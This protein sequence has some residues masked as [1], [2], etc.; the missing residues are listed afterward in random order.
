MTAAALFTGDASAPVEVVHQATGAASLVWL[1]VALPLLSAMLLLVGGRRTNSW[2]PYLGVGVVWVGFGIGF[3]QFLQMLG[4]PTAARPVGQS[5]YTWAQSGLFDVKVQFLLDELSM[6]FV[7][8]ITFVGGLIHVYSLGYMKE[9]PDRRRFFAYLNLFVASMLLL[10]VAGNYVMVY[11]GWEG[12]GLASYLLIGFWN[13][14]RTYATAGN[15]AFVMN[16]LGDMGMSIA[17]MV[18]FAT[19]GTSTFTGVFAK[20]PDASST[21]TL[22]LGLLLLL[23]AVGKSAQIPLQAWLL[24]AMAGPTPV[25]ALIHAATMVTAGVYLIVRSGPI[26]DLTDTAR[27]VVALVGVLTLLLGALIGTA[28]DDIKKALA[29]STMSQIGYMVLAAG[30]GPA[31][32]AFAIFHLLMHGFFKANLFLGAGS[33]MHAMN[34]ELDMRRFGGLRKLLPI[35]FLTFMAGYLAIIGVPPFDGFYSKD[36]I[37][38]AAFGQNLW[39]G[40]A[41][42]VGAGI[43]GYY[44]TRVVIMTWFGP[45]RWDDEV[46]PHESPWVM[47]VPLIFLGVLSTVA[48]FI[49]AKDSRF[50]DWLAPVVGAPPESALSV[51]TWVVSVG[52]LALVGVGAG[53]AYLQYARRPVPLLAPVG[54]PVTVAAR[55]DFYEDSLN[56]VVVMRPG[57]YLVRFLVWFDN[58]VIDGVVNGSAALIGGSSGRLRRWQNGF[59]RSYALSMAAGAV[60]IV[61]ALVLVRL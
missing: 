11:V 54:S 22:W 32:Y 49:L 50:V 33:V 14:N 16:R 56:E 59:V 20:A 36:K 37:I 46:H 44:M 2:G 23:A 12:V 9:D 43:T 5:I 42:A 25:S 58:K 26:F 27:T 31:G 17:I 39:L 21:V 18:M 1:L 61:G 40:L 19:F 29:G 15:K 4:R 34:D 45:R 53:W 47:T 28:K 10:V 35:T 60:L 51:P 7:L 13:R 57:Q 6:V 30:L 41:A 3:V 8:L 24:D 38:E 48:G 55:R 52:V